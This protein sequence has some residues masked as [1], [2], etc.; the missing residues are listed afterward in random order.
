MYYVFAIRL[1]LFIMSAAIVTADSQIPELRVPRVSGDAVK[2]DGVADEPV[3][4]QATPI[5]L[6]SYWPT[7]DTAE[8]TTVRVL[9]TGTELLVSFVCEDAQTV[10]THTARDDHTFRDDC[11]EIFLA[12]P[13]P[14]PLHEGLNIEISADGAWADVLFRYPN[15]L[16]YD[17]NPPGIRVAVKII[18]GG[19]IAELALPF[20]DIADVTKI[21]GYNAVFNPAHQDFRQAEATLRTLPPHRLRANFA[22][23][24]R[25][26]NVLTIW[27][28][29]QRPTPHALE[30]DRYGWLVFE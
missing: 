25:P 11:A 20:A 30:P 10:A 19:W 13:L 15:W 22:R 27:S 26:E 17:W 24:H 1:F 29:P 2:I 5:A 14:G 3:W 6:R 28:D 23:W 9:H 12:A 18:P 7:R 21:G 4:Q 16:N 8:K